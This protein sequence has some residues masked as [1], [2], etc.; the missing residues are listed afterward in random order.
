MK[1]GDEHRLALICLMQKVKPWDF[2]IKVLDDGKREGP[3]KLLALYQGER[4]IVVGDPATRV[5]YMPV[6]N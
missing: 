4:L 5:C 2:T 3:H 6:A 1:R